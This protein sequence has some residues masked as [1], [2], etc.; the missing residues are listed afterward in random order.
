MIPIKV[1]LLLLFL[2]F[3]ATMSAESITIK[4][5]GGNETVLDLAT[6]PV[7]TFSGENMVITN[8]FTTISFPL[9]DIDSYVVGNTSSGIHELSDAPTFHDGH[10]VLHGMKQGSSIQ[11]YTI[12]GRIV[13]RIVADGSD[14]L[15]IHLGS[16]LKGA[17]IIRTPNTNIKVVN[18]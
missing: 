11:I 17:Y 8:D 9:G 15:D 16:L 13:S 12:D 6:H 4:Q 5:K 18:N 10:L 7:I 14:M 2:C 1:K 3:S